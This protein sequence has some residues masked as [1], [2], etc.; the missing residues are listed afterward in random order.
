MKEIKI[1]LSGSTRSKYIDIIIT[2][3]NEGYKINKEKLQNFV[4]RRKAS[5]NPFSTPRLEEDKVVYVKGFKEEN[6][7]TFLTTKK[8]HFRVYNKDIKKDNITNLSSPIFRPSHADFVSYFKYGKVMPGGGVFSGRLMIGLA[9]AGAICS[10]ILSEENI[11]TFAYI[12]QIG[13][14]ELE[15]YSNTQFETKPNFEDDK[16][17]ILNNSK[18]DILF[19]K[20]KSI[21]E[22]GDSIGGKIDCVAINLPIGLGSFQFLNL[23]SKISSLIFSIPAVKALE[24]GLGTEFALKKGSEANDE[25]Y[26]DE[27]NNI[28]TY[29]NNNGGINGGITN[30]MPLTFKTTIKP[31]ASISKEQRTVMVNPL[32]ETILELKGRNDS[33][34][35]P[36][37]V[38]L[39]ESALNIVLVD[40]IQNKDEI[41]KKEMKELNRRFK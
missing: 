23:E 15:N 18:K 38:V 37:A 12:S 36:R 5:N 2:N 14:I 30:S 16:F 13:N 35:V 24:F 1:N 4:D 8:M 11:E 41:F 39:V 34:I 26:L 19:E 21:N 9:I 27:N 28:K 20:L 32:Q 33:C 22:E 25:L 3:L 10:Q 7:E 40:Y 31:T 6:N 17:R 29:T